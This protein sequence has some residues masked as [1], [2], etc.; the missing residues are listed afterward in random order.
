MYFCR[1]NYQS[2]GISTVA[3][4]AFDMKTD[5]I[6]LITDDNA[7]YIVKKCELP[8][9]AYENDSDSIQFTDLT[10]LCEAYRFQ[11][12]IDVCAEDLIKNDEI[13]NKYSVSNTSAVTF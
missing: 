1:D 12:T 11:E 8:E 3:L 4:A 2:L 10:N 7:A 5:E 13:I 6:K 9:R